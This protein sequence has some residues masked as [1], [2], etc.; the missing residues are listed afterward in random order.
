SVGS[1]IKSRSLETLEGDYRDIALNVMCRLT[2]LSYHAFD[3]A[4][5]LW[6]MASGLATGATA[7]TRLR[8]TGERHRTHGLGLLL[9]KGLFDARGGRICAELPGSGAGTSVL[10]APA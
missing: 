2:A 5:R 9:S 8:R 3:D 10:M 7:R 4:A 6:T 1:V